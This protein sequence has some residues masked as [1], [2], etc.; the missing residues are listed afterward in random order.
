MF[1]SGSENSQ[2]DRRVRGFG[3]PSSDSDGLRG[4][5]W[6]SHAPLIRSRARMFRSGSENSQ[7][8]RR[9]RGFEV[10]VRGGGLRA[11]RPRPSAPL[12]RD[13]P[14]RSAV[15]SPAPQCAGPP[16]CRASPVEPRRATCAPPFRSRARMFGSG[17]ENSQRYPR[18]RDQARG[19]AAGRRQRATGI[20][21]DAPAG[22]PPPRA[23]LPA[24]AR[25]D[26]LRKLASRAAS[27]ATSAERCGTRN[28]G[29][30]AENQI[31]GDT[32][33]H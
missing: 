12:R 2:R 28:V 7:R 25:P 22:P 9:V 17:R 33:K 27:A 4:S 14:R 5:G 31:V 32:P 15:R 18:T 8:D 30:R 19:R 10:Q 26:Q 29:G 13:P 16:P 21:D 6:R 3:L 11:A 24:R 23:T 1:G 20:R